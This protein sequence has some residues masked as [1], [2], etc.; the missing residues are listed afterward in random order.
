MTRPRQSALGSRRAATMGLESFAKPKA[1]ATARE[2]FASPDSL[3]SD[4]KLV[5]VTSGTGDS[6]GFDLEGHGKW[7][8]QCPGTLWQVPLWSWLSFHDRSARGAKLCLSP[9]DPSPAAQS[10]VCVEADSGKEVWKV[11]RESDGLPSASICMRLPVAFRKGELNFLITHGNDYCI[12]HDP[13]TGK[14]QWR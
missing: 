13:L 4:G 7:L 6:R 1:R 8:P 11:E 5:F 2:P 3:S 9:V 10:V 12:G 14:E